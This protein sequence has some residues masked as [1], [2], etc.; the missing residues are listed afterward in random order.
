MA[1]PRRHKLICKDCKTEIFVDVNM[2][3][4]KNVLWKKICDKDQDAICDKCMENRMGRKITK[5]DFKSPSDKFLSIIPCNAMWL[6]NKDQQ[7][8][9]I[10][11]KNK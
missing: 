3:M 6:W 7:Q 11:I 5:K 1:N 2:V 10:K 4:I 9:Q 8:K